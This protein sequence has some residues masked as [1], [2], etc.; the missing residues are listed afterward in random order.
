MY[1]ERKKI[2]LYINLYIFLCYD[3]DHSVELR[4]SW[5]ELTWRGTSQKFVSGVRQIM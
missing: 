4:S 5:T 1:L 2:R 3:I